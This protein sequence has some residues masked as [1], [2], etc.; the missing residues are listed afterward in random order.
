MQIVPQESAV[1]QY[2]GCPTPVPLYKNHREMV[3]FKSTSDAGFLSAIDGLANIVKAAL[4]S[5]EGPDDF[6][7]PEPRF[8]GKEENPLSGLRRFD[9]VFLIDDSSTMAGAKWALVR[10]ILDRATKIATKYDENGVDIQFLNDENHNRTHITSSAFI[11]QTLTS[12]TPSGSTP[13]GAQLQ[14]HLRAYLIYFKEQ[15]RKRPNSAR[16]RNLIILT[17]GIP[18]EPK[19]TIKKTIVKM[20]KALDKENAVDEQ[21]GIQ[22]CVIGNEP[23]VAEFYSSLDNDLEESEDLDRDVSGSLIYMNTIRSNQV[24]R[25]WTGYNV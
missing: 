25:W 11:M 3:K 5:Q 23:G 1:L 17:D 24:S 20:A 13:L 22:F 21:L 2:D 19:A 9:T 4:A 14:R 18:D 6:D 8:S 10:A 15:E 7:D 16:P 12:V